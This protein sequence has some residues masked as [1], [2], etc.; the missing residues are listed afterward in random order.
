VEV[1]IHFDGGTLHKVREGI[2]ETICIY[3]SISRRRESPFFTQ[4]IILTDFD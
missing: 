2:G 1:S 4:V 3:L